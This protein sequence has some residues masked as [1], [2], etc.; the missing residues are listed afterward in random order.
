MLHLFFLFVPS[1]KKDIELARRLGG[2]GRPWWLDNASRRPL[3]LLFVKLHT[4]GGTREYREFQ[5]RHCCFYTQ[6]SNL[7]IIWLLNVRN[8]TLTNVC[9]WL[10][11]RRWNNHY[12]MVATIYDFNLMSEVIVYHCSNE[13]FQDYCHSC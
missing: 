7:M 2:I 4:V 9:Q 6:H 13:I 10:Y 5:W 1:V 11:L 8:Y 12:R 3:V